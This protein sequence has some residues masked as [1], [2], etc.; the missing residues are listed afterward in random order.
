MGNMQAFTLGTA[1]FGKL[2]GPR[3]TVEREQSGMSFVAIDRRGTQRLTV[4]ILQWAIKF[5][6][7]PRGR[8]ANRDEAKRWNTASLERRA[9]LCPVLFALPGDL[10]LVMQRATPISE[11]DAQ[12]LRDTWGFPDWGEFD[13]FEDSP[14]EPKASDWGRL[15]DGRL[16]ALDYAGPGF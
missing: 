12:K 4:C 1:K 15:P 13:P 7:G 5:A 16:V 2:S 14:F 8:E 10:A 11:A 3:S 6:R 9:I